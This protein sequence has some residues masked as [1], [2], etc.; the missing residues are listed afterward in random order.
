MRIAVTGAS[1]NLGSALVRRL[2]ADGTHQVLGISRRAPDLLRP[3]LTWAEIDL[4]EP[5]SATRLA[6]AFDG[7]DAVVHLAWQIQ[8]GRDIPRLHAV[9]VD[10][11]RRVA[12][13]AA[14]AGVEH[15]VVVTSIGSYGPGPDKARE[16]R[17]VDESWPTTGIPTST[18]SRHKAEVE[19]ILDDVEAAH[20]GLAVT[21]IRPALV[22]QAGAASEIARLFLGPLVPTR[23][24]GRLPLP[25]LPLPAQLTFQVVHADDVATAIST[26][27]E[28]RAAGAYNVASEPVLTP[29]DLARAIGARRAVPLPLVVLRTAATITWHAR[30]QPT[31]A[32]WVDLAAKSPLISTAAIRKLGWTPR[33]TTHEALAEL[34][35]AMREGKG[36]DGYPPLHSR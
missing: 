19:R 32:G 18:Y 23:L 15:L 4:A 10:G 12:E 31:D 28:Q 3:R 21:R 14:A 9:N 2:E 29:Q 20:P 25:V 11:S 17:E 22:F 6:T 8:P 27:L 33:R 34:I 30:L 1:G 13:A 5:E 24:A 35:T 16:P 7:V 26:V 36:A